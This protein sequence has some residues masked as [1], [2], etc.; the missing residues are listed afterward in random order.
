MVGLTVGRLAVPFR[1]N[2]RRASS[3]I[4]DR[5][6][7]LTELVDE[8]GQ[9][10]GPKQPATS[11]VM[12]VEANALIRGALTRSLRTTGLNVVG[13][14]SSAEDAIDILERQR[15]DIMLLGLELPGMSGLDFL[16]S[17]HRQHPSLRVV[18]LA[19]SPT[20]ADV[21]AAMA[22]GA[23]GCL[24]HDIPPDALSRALHG[25]MEGHLAMG[26]P[27]AALLMR[28]LATLIDTEPTRL[29]AADLS[30]LTA[31]ETQVLALVADGLT[32]REIA[33]ELELSMRTVEKH[34]SNTLHKLGCRER[35]EAAA[36]Y[37][38][39]V[40]IQSAIGGSLS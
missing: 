11:R 37:R 26:R 19:E 20:D 6:V 27:M 7:V 31:R 14:V 34:V 10:K 3:G 35:R 4:R 30:Q 22:V 17:V 23:W 40:K 12:I 8:G 29:S 24:T 18:V 38:P 25:V 16:K 2:G 21:L 15:P 32:D 13:A 33:A 1:A 28:R 39:P 9:I 5:A 36:R